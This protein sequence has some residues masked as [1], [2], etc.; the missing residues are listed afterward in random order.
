MDSSEKEKFTMKEKGGIKK[1]KSAKNL[2]I[3]PDVWSCINFIK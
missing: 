2:I 1:E 3:C